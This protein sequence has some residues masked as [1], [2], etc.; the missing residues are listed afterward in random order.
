MLYQTTK[1]LLDVRPSAAAPLTT[2]APDLSPARVLSSVAEV[3]SFL[4]LERAPTTVVEARS[5]DA[6][7]SLEFTTGSTPNSN[8]KG[9]RPLSKRL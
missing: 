4:S 9:P 8:Y 7:K 2:I 3:V 6:R 5:D 1:N